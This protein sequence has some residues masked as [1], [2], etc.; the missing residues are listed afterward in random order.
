[1]RPDFID[2]RAAEGERK[3]VRG[4]L[5]LLRKSMGSG[6]L[7]IKVDAENQHARNKI[8]GDSINCAPSSIDISSDPVEDAFS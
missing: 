7:P 6:A 5:A 3:E 8:S 2:D 1:M 4:P